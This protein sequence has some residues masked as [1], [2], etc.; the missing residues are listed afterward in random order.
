MLVRIIISAIYSM[1]GS[2]TKRRFASGKQVLNSSRLSLFHGGISGSHT[3]TSVQMPPRQSLPTRR[4]SKPIPKM[5]VSCMKVT[6]CASALGYVLRSE[7][8]TSE[9]Q[10][11]DHLVC[12]LLLEKK[13]K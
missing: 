11:P 7:E 8:H 9:L 1:T 5:L 13:K 3:S 2:V 6:N 4:H 12:R 10:S